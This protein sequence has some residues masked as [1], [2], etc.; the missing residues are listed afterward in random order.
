MG[1][2]TSAVVRGLSLQSRVTYYATVKAVDFTGKSSSIVSRGVS[3]D[4]T[5]PIVEGV[6]LTGLTQFQ[7]SLQLAW[8]G[9][10]DE[11]S[12]ISAVEWG[13]GTRAGSSDI[14]GWTPVSLDLNTGIEIDTRKLNLYD[15]QTIF[16]SLKVSSNVVNGIG[17]TILAFR[18]LQVRNG[19]G[20]VSVSS[21]PAYT[22]DSS[23][24]DVGGVFDGPPT[25]SSPGGVDVDYWGDGRVLEAHWRGFS[26]PH[27]S[28]T[29]YWWTIGSCPE[30]TDIQPWLS[31]GIQQGGCGL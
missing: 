28:I 19:A 8:N 26:D 23:P 30:C 16:A 9:I 17:F 24:P 1:V 15:G 10:L 14:A 27:T 20:V 31:V 2:A 29:E 22:L 18:F 4:T 21:S 6:V 11:E 3:I 5:D 7:T 25:P 12:G 13:L